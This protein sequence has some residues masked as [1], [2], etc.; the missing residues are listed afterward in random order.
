M[1]PTFRDASWAW[2]VS[3]AC[4]LAGRARALDVP[5]LTDPVVDLTGVLDSDTHGA[6]DAALRDYRKRVGPQI[7]VL[8]ISSLGGVPIE[9]YSIRV[10]EKWKLGDPA[11]DD[12]VLLLVALKDRQW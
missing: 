4:V 12:G 7:E 1:R 3:A 6:L 9:D 8:L 10:V 11:R 2:V 5:P